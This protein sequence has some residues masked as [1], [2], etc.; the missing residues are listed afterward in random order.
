MQNKE[1]GVS[2]SLNPSLIINPLEELQKQFCL[3]DIGGEIRIADRV[4]INNVI[5]GVEMS[6]L[7]FY[8]KQHGNTRLRRLLENLPI[9]CDASKTIM[10]F[11]NNR[12][13]K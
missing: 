8:T 10:A 12:A 6:E 7:S 3:I 13:C 2:D 11:W 4:K 1:A 9:D 5:N